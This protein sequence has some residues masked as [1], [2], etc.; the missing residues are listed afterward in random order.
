MG[1]FDRLREASRDRLLER[2]RM[3]ALIAPKNDCSAGDVGEAGE[4]WP[5]D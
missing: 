1:D 3:C 4:S 5:D 2:P